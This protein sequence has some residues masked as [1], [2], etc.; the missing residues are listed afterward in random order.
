MRSKY[1]YT[2]TART[3]VESGRTDIDGAM[4]QADRPGRKNGQWLKARVAGRGRVGREC[5]D[6]DRCVQCIDAIDHHTRLHD[7]LTNLLHR[8]DVGVGRRRLGAD[9]ECQ[10]QLVGDLSDAVDDGVRGSIRRH[11]RDER[12]VDLQGTDRELLQRAHLPTQLISP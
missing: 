4:I 12:L 8:V 1:G 5:P 10:A 7:E 9:V 6:R 3:T 11:A 2:T